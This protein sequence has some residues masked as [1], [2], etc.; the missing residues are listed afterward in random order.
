MSRI[1]EIGQMRQAFTPCSISDPLLGQLVSESLTGF[2]FVV[3]AQG[4]VEF[5]SDSSS[6]QVGHAPEQI[7]GNQIYNFLHPSDHSRFGCHLVHQQPLPTSST[8]PDKA[9]RNFTCRFKLLHNQQTPA[10]STTSNTTGESYI[11]LY[12]AC[13][14]V[15]R[16]QEKAET[17]RLLCVARKLSDVSPHPLTMVTTTPASVIPANNNAVIANATDLFMTKLHPTTF[18]VMLADTSPAAT[19]S[20]LRASIGIKFYYL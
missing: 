17:S 14:T 9:R 7:R 1:G 6:E 12:V 5:V 13:I 4:R 11:T 19:N 10:V 16:K 3:D 15:R 8:D 20:R 18:K 2:I